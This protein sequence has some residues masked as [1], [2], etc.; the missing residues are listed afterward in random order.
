MGL[1]WAQPPQDPVSDTGQRARERLGLAAPLHHNLQG[2]AMTPPSPP[3]GSPPGELLELEGSASSLQLLL[4]KVPV[5]LK[6]L[7]PNVPFSLGQPAQVLSGTNILLQA[8]RS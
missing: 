3:G 1:A 4:L 8:S 7:L 6:L 5:P 2:S